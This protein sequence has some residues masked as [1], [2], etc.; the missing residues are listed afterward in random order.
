MGQSEVSGATEGGRRAKYTEPQHRREALLK[1]IFSHVLPPAFIDVLD[2]AA[3][4]ELGDGR[5]CCA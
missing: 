4:H 5:A 3:R 2:T 1:L